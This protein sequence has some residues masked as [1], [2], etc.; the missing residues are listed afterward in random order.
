[1]FLD[2]TDRYICC[3]Q[4]SLKRKAASDEKAYEVSTPEFR[5]IRVLS[6]KLAFLIDAVLRDILCNICA[7]RNLVKRAASRVAHFQ[8]RARSGISL[9]KQEEIICK[10]LRQHYQICLCVAAAHAG[11]L[12]RVLA[13]PD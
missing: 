11:G 12:P 2:L 3:N 6:F 7:L 5:D 4:I 10:I 1:M 8:Q 9:R 13:F